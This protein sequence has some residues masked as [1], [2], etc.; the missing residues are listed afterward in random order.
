[1]K[2]KLLKI[3][4]LIMVIGLF[5]SCSKEYIGGSYFYPEDFAVDVFDVYKVS[6]DAYRVEYAVTNL[7]NIDYY[8]GQDGDFY[9]EFS[10]VGHNG[11]PFYNEAPIGTLY[12]GESFRGT[13]IIRVDPRLGYDPNDISYDIYDAGR[14]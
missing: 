14:Y 9:L 2:S 10:L 1:M 13:M 11:A 6:P 8:H 7:S 5:S 3:V 12:A 4:A